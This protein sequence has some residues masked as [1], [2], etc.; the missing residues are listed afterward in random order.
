M[1]SMMKFWGER[2]GCHSSHVKFCETGMV[3]YICGDEEM[4][5]VREFI[6]YQVGNSVICDI[7]Y[8]VV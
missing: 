3:D 7:D 4:F 8:I 2:E 6:R 1:L 5:W